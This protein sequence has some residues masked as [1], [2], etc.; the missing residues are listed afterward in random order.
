MGVLDE[1]GE[2]AAVQ[3]AVGGAGE[4]GEGGVAQEGAVASGARVRCDAQS[5]RHRGAP[6]GGPLVARPPVD[7][8]A[9]RRR[10][11]LGQ[12]GQQF[13]GPRVCT[14]DED[15]REIVQGAVA[16]GVQQCLG[17]RG[18]GRVRGGGQWL[19]VVEPAGELRLHGG[20]VGGEKSCHG[21]QEAGP[22]LARRP[23]GVDQPPQQRAA[24]FLGQS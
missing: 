15:V 12:H 6:P 2:G 10:L 18:D 4:L 19:L 5:V 7:G 22:G 13:V 20:G 16:E 17:G 3:G 23:V 21:V 11:L 1:E 14:V 9:H 8:P 24:Y